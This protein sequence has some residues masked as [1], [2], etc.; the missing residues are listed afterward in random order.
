MK[1]TQKTPIPLVVT[2]LYKGIFFG[3][4]IPTTKK[5]IRLTNAQMCVYFCDTKSVLGLASTGPN[6]KCKVGPAA[7]AITLQDVT[8]IIECSKQAEAMWKLQP[9]N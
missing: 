5:T 7:P 8:A 2:T 3:Y 6:E 1:E 4:G 9:W